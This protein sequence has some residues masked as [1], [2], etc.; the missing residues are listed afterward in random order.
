MMTDATRAFQLLGLTVDASEDTVRAAFRNQVIGLH[1]DVVGDAGSEPTLALLDAYRTAIHHA[2]RNLADGTRPPP[3]ANTDSGETGNT[4]WLVDHDTIALACPHEEA[5]ARVLEVGHALGSITYLDREGE[6]LEVL[7]RT[8][9][10]DTVS[11]VISFQGRTDWVEAFLTTQVLDTAKH[12][13]PSTAQITELYAH[14]L[15]A[16]WS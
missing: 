4:V 3:S 9:L 6:L 15:V 12:E 14:Q 8:K 2:A 13:L 7:L 11:L 5:F 1:P 16:R 10:G